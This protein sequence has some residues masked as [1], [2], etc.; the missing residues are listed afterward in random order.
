MRRENLNYY[1]HF[2]DE[3]RLINLNRSMDRNLSFSK[4]TRTISEIAIVL[5]GA[6]EKNSSLMITK[7]YS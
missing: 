7:N 3:E 4:Q 2:S 6:S 5:D 1:Y